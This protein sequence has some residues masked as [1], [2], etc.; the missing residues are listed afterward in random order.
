LEQ[1]VERI[2]IAVKNLR[3][4]VPIPSA[5]T[6]EALQSPTQPVGFGFMLAITTGIMAVFF[7]YI[8]IG[9]LL[10]PLQIGLLAPATKVTT[11]SFFMG[12]SV[13]FGIV[14]N[15]LAGALSDRTTSRF[16]R[17][18]PWIVVGSLLTAVCLFT[19]MQASTLWLLFVGWCGIQIFSN[20]ILVAISATIPDRVPEKQ[21]GTVAGITGLA[22]PLGS[23]LGFILVGLVLKVPHTS[24]AV[25]IAGVLVFTLPLGLFM[26]DK[27]LPKGYL[28]SF[29][30]GTFLKRFWIDPREYP[31]FTWAWLTRFTPYVGYF[32]ASN[33]MLYYLQDAVKYPSPLQGSSMFN[34]LSTS[35][36]FVATILVGILSDRF[37]RRK[38]FVILSALILAISL[39][40]LGFFP[41]WQFV[42]LAAVILGIGFGAYNA[43]DTAIT[44]LVLPSAEDHAKDLG[45]VN[46]AATLPQ[47]L[48]P[49]IAGFIL[50]LS[51]SYTLMYAVAFVFVLLSIAMVMQIKTVR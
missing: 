33:Y 43:V 34:S 47:S 46:I 15:P 37:N 18:R 2:S 4:S 3:M 51:H 16:G 49:V 10:L 9:A 36:L 32:M 6:P 48:A 25:M 40:V 29:H 19:M 35:A 30:L 17:R 12:V 23:L 50:S 21:R 8:G 14:T 13:L 11:L 44:T 31:D 1:S 5:E 28:P 38:L 45:I 39:L 27:V 7:C 26:R 20:F 24:Y 41:I 42:L 22:I